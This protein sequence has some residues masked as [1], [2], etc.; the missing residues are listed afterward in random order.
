MYFSYSSQCFI[1]C[2]PFRSI[3]FFVLLTPFNIGRATE[4]KFILL[5]HMQSN[6]VVMINVFKWM[7]SSQSSGT[8]FVVVVVVFI[9]ICVNTTTLN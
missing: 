3:F 6:P 7:D 8:F 9:L 4:N 2:D 1:F 5:N